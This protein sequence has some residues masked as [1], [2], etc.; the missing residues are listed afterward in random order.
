M[1]DRSE[2][3]RLKEGD[4]FPLLGGEISFGPSIQRYGKR[5]GPNDYI[6][7]FHVYSQH[8]MKEQ[9]DPDEFAERKKARARFKTARLFVGFPSPFLC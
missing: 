4:S 3:H 8:E 5:T 2:C 6:F 9:L 7:T 1:N